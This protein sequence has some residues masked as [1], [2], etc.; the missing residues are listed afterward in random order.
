[1]CL[2]PAF[3][4]LLRLD[5]LPEPPV[6]PQRSVQLQLQL[7]HLLRQALRAP[8]AAGPRA[9]RPH[10]GRLRGVQALQEVLD[11]RAAGQR[12]GRRDGVAHVVAVALQLLEVLLVAGRLLEDLPQRALLGA[13]PLQAPERLGDPFSKK[14]NQVQEATKHVK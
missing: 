8:R 1:M 14:G 12:G 7:L 6:L 13:L 5:D 10:L 11:D 2:Q 9:R 4:S 3:S